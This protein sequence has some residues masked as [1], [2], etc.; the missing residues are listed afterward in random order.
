MKTLRALWIFCLALALG[1]GCSPPG[2]WITMR[3]GGKALQLELADTPQAH[4]KGLQGRRKLS[5]NQGMLFVFPEKRPLHFWSKDTTLALS[6]AF[7]DDDG[8][9]VQIEE[10]PPQSSRPVTSSAACRY[11]LELASG[12]FEKNGVKVGDALMMETR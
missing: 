10:M 3:L 6:I 7:L 5:E 9:I 4:Q 2:K 1:A 11:A 12:W 8:K